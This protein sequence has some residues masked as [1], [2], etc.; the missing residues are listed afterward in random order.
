VAALEQD[1]E[2]PDGQERGELVPDVAVDERGGQRPPPV[3]LERPD[4][5]QV[6]AVQEGEDEIAD[7]PEQD[8]GDR[9]VGALE[10]VPADPGISFVRSRP[11]VGRGGLRIRGRE[12]PS[13]SRS[14]FGAR[15]RSRCPQ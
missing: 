9:D 12:E 10:V 14:I 1:A 3:R 8:E 7:R 5:R 2:D 4:D 11:S 6:A 13:S 15:L